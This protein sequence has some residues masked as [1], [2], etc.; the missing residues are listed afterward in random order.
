MP[1]PVAII[2]A[3]I[4]ITVAISAD[5]SVTVSDALLQCLSGKIEVIQDDSIPLK[6]LCPSRYTHVGEQSW[7]LAGHSFPTFVFS[8][9][10]IPP[11]HLGGNWTDNVVVSTVPLYS[12]CPDVF[13]HK[14]FRERNW[15]TAHFL[16]D[17]RCCVYANGVGTL[18]HIAQG[19]MVGFE[20]AE[21]IFAP[22]RTEEAKMPSEVVGTETVSF[23]PPRQKMR[24]GQIHLV[25]L[26]IGVTCLTPAIFLRQSRFLS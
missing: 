3:S 15:Y 10:C 13:V 8:H 24:G 18:I 12:E 7:Q 19:N 1:L 21:D 14:E 25:A 22:P 20:S 11:I 26:I 9:Q 17:F 23:L 16:S 4:A 2:T 6:I 5:S